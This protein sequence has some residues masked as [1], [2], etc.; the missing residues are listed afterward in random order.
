MHRLDHLRL[1][2]DRGVEGVHHANIDG[3]V[4]LCADLG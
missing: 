1:L 4:A 3:L 2:V